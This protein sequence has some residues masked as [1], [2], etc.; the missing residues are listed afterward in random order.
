MRLSLIVLLLSTIVW[1][2]NT[3]ADLS[4][5]V[6]AGK[7]IIEKT[8][9]HAFERTAIIGYQFGDDLFI[10][11]TVGYYFTNGYGLSSLWVSSIVGVKAKTSTGP[12]LSIGVGPSYLFNP[13]NLIL[14]GNFQFN[15]EGCVGVQSKYYIG[16]CWNHLSNAGLVGPVNFG[17][18]F[19][20][21]TWRFL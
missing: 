15:L 11:P 9:D 19:L 8:R 17:R 10:R 4:L 3:F 1:C 5:S 7:S 16:M 13:D 18:D 14:S 2:N 21:V 20:M 12:V 6:G